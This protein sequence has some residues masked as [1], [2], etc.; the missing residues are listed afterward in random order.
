M[1]SITGVEN[2]SGGGSSKA[3]SEVGWYILRVNQE[4]VGPYALSGLQEHFKN[5]YISET[6]LLWAEG[7]TEWLS[8]SSIPEL[9]TGISIRGSEPT[10]TEATSDNDNEFTKWQEEIRKAEL[11]AEVLKHGS[12]LNDVGGSHQL[13]DLEGML[14]RGLPHHLMERKNSLI[15]MELCTSGTEVL[16]HGFPK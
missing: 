1:I 14:T 2:S 12:R 3:I 6:T 11:E 7:R 10:V 8:L 9:F 15:I 4:H 13:K 5:G 16:E